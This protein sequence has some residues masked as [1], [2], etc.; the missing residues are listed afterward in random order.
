[1]CNCQNRIGMKRKRIGK[2]GFGGLQNILVDQVLPIA[3]GYLLGNI[4]SKQLTMLS[5]NPTTGNLVKLAAGTFMATQGGMLGGLGVGLASNGAAGFVQPALESAG[6][7]LLPPGVPSYR[8]NGL[9]GEGVDNIK[10]I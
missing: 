7:G 6:L 2:A 1:M 10:T 3:G 5:S 8:V 4:V 9:G